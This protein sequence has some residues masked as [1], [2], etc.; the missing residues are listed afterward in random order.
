VNEPVYIHRYTLRSRA[1]L[2]AR[3]S[4]QEYRGVLIQVNGGYGCIHPWPEL[5][6]APLEEQLDLLK[7]GESSPLIRSALSCAHADGQARREGRS[8][9]EGIE[10]PRSH[11]TLPMDEHAF[12]EAHAA[13]FDR[14]KVK[15]GRD[16]KQESDFVQM[17][18]EY[19][20]ELRWRMDFNNSQ[21]VTEIKKM[22]G[23]W[24][25]ALLEKID[26]LEDAYMSGDAIG[27]ISLINP[28]RPIPQA[29]DRE[30]SHPPADFP[31]WVIKPA[32]NEV[33]P[34]LATAACQKKRVV[35]TSYMDHP[36]GQSYAAWQAGLATAQ[37]PELI[38][39]CGLV[40]HGLFEPDVFTE[41]IGP[42][43][44]Q[45]HPAPGTGLGFDNLLEQLPWRRLS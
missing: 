43:S 12:A 4:R 3:T 36:I 24:G 17:M 8:L 29:L 27:L 23:E 42:P 13:G 34:L 37:Y 40:T 16:L 26:F 33:A 39:I 14:V 45:F 25:E 38:G 18:A 7:N 21:P 32:V 6:D 28:I 22:L 10:V 11:A 35:V 19:Y 41:A 5:G 30:V 9:F 31:V 44:A 2:N 1:S 15:M 20:P